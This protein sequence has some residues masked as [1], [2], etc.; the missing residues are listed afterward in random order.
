M[1]AYFGD[2]SFLVTPGGLT[3]PQLW[4]GIPLVSAANFASFALDVFGW[5][6]A[7]HSPDPSNTRRLG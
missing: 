4:E 2:T 5:L 1:H 3:L 7:S 6:R